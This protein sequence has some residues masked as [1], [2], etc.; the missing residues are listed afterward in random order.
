MMKE[1]LNECL[2]SKPAELQADA[3]LDDAGLD[4]ADTEDDASNDIVD[5]TE[6]VDTDDDASD[7]IEINSRPSSKRAR[8]K[9][10]WY[11]ERGEYFTDDEN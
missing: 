2:K 3:G 6:D 4:D 9:P 10:D 5:L 1:F 11:A 7:D 8:Q